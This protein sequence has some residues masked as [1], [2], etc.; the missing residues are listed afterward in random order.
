MKKQASDMGRRQMLKAL[1][2]GSAA[3][4]VASVSAPAL[5]QVTKPSAEPTSSN[6]RET[7]HILN[8]YASLRK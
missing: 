2:L 4:A 8:Y 6:Y 1:A 3:G 7:E 5:A